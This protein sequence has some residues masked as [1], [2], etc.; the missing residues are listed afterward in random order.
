MVIRFTLH[1]VYV[2]WQVSVP[3]R[4]GRT[5]SVRVIPRYMTIAYDLAG[6]LAGVE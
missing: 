2:F 1:R 6:P 3:I 4:F 5:P